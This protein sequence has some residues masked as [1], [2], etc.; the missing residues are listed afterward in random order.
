M[1]VALA[2]QAE[3]PPFLP[4]AV[5]VLNDAQK[6]ILKLFQ[7]DTN[8]QLWL[9]VRK[10]NFVERASAAHRI[11]SYNMLTPQVVSIGSD[12]ETGQICKFAKIMNEDTT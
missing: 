6:E 3:A 4:E 9:K 1:I 8:I 11:R 10:M 5:A 7:D 2:P 12:A